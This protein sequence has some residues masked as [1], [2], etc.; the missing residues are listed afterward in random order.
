M[1]KNKTIAYMLATTLLVGGTFL[2]TKALFTDNIN[3]IGELRISTG[4]VDIEVVSD[5]KWELYRNGAEYSEG[6]NI[7]MKYNEGDEQDINGYAPTNDLKEI[8]SSN[9]ANNLKPG[10][11]LTKT[12][13][14]KNVGTLI[15]EVDF[16]QD[17]MSAKLGNL[18]GLVIASE[19][20][21]QGEDV[22]NKGENGLYEVTLKPGEEM[23]IEL[24]LTVDSNGK[25]AHDTASVKP[26]G[27]QSYNTNS[28]ENEVIN[29]TN[30]WILDAT[31]QNK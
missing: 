2:G 5:N 11:E 13:V 4:D 18:K 26:V 8:Q 15:A 27:E 23:E 7:D 10:D 21:K 16:K 17:D 22:I 25:G 9:F 20:L 29:L 24:Q 19:T 31:Q 6:T 3:D 1:K 28:I 12:V 30:A 14:V